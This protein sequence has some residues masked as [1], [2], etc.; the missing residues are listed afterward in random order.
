[1]IES[2]E[3]IKQ[4][5]LGIGRRLQ[6]LAVQDLIAL[7]GLVSAG[8]GLIALL[9]LGIGPFETRI[10]GGIGTGGSLVLCGIPLAA[11]GGLVGLRHFL[12]KRGRWRSNLEADADQSDFIID[13]ALDLDD[14]VQT[15]GSIIRR[16]GPANITGR[17][18]GVQTG[19]RRSRAIR[20]ILPSEA[21]LR[22]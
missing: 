8:F 18:R 17:G 2:G 12:R 13:R 15:A 10:A 20:S 11:A 1:M 6:L 9:L 16:G 21:G 5:E 4:L 22:G 14:R 3:S 7:S 19:R